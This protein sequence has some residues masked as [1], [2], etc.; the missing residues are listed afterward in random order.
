MLAN[1]TAQGF[2]Y[3]RGKGRALLI[4]DWAN[5][6]EFDYLVNR[7]RSN[8]IEVDVMPSDQLYTDLSQLQIY[9]VIIL[10]NCPRTSGET[11]DKITNFSDE[12]ISMLV[13]SVEHMGCGLVVFGG[14]QSYGAGG[15]NNTELEKALPVDCQIRNA[16]VNAVGALAMVMHASEIPA[17]NYWQKVVAIEAMEALGPL[18]YCGVIQWN[19]FGGEQWMWGGSSGMLPVGPNRRM[20]RSRIDR[21][22]PGDMPDFD[23]GLRMALLGLKRTNAAIKHMIVISDGDPT[24]PSQSVLQ[25]FVDAGIP[26]STVAVAAHG[27]PEQAIL[28]NI[29][30]ITG[31]NFYAVTN[32]RALPRIFQREARRVAKPVIFERSG[33]PVQIVMDHPSHALVGTAV[34]AVD[35]LVLTTV[36]ENPL[37]EVPIRADIPQPSENTALL[38]TWTY[39]L[40]RVAAWTSDAGHRWADSWTGTG[41]YD[42]LFT[43]VIRWAMRPS[44]IGEKYE[45]TSEYRDGKVRVVVTAASSE[46]RFINL[47]RLSGT[48]LAPDG[49]SRS[50]ELQQVAP[51]RYVGEFNADVAGNYFVTIL[52]GGEEVE[53]NGKKVLRP[54]AP[55]ISGVTVPYSAEYNDRQTNRALL[56]FFAKLKPKGGEPGV[57]VEPD[58]TDETMDE[59]LKGYDSFRSTLAPAVSL[60]DAWPLLLLWAAILFWVDIAVRRVHLQFEW[61]QA[62]SSWLGATRT[63]QRQREQELQQRLDQLRATKQT[64]AEQLDEVR[65]TARFQPPMVPADTDRITEVFGTS[66]A[67]PTTPPVQRSAEAE[68]LQKAEES[69]TERLLK[70]KQQAR[71]WNPR[72]DDS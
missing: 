21:M 44:E 54:R 28:Q 5:R 53:E 15:W 47:D 68:S 62:L 48:L 29:A 67:G 61:L 3:V 17:G 64:A 1:N 33:I 24:P 22:T 11:A 13:Q 6:G 9:D 39:G 56:E 71:R 19:N 63:R 52:A 12:Q 59:I 42:R 49:Q 27:A 20:M 23:P 34:P 58:L 43:Q 18:D 14:P 8:A 69:Y 46:D 10:A 25:A 60:Q 36:K 40:G 51:G 50:L 16:K 72:K 35:G 45:V 4:E 26:I 37:V 32:P 41:Q 57:M 31:G 55:L 65:R 70:A 7:L 2:T 38:A 66:S 30:R